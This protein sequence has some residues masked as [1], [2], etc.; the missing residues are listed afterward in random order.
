MVINKIKVFLKTEPKNDPE[1]VRIVHAIR[2]SIGNKKSSDEDVK[3]IMKA[4]G[5]KTNFVYV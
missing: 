1:W 4:R 3:E 2:A 5:L